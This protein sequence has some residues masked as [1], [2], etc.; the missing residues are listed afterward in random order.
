MATASKEA[1]RRDAEGD[2][3]EAG[4]G[5]CACTG[6]VSGYN[7]DEAQLAGGPPGCS[8]GALE[9]VAA[10]VGGMRGEEDGEEG[11]EEGCEEEEVVIAVVAA[12]FAAGVLC[13][14]RGERVYV[15]LLLWVPEQC[16]ALTAED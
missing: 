8:G 3:E 5:G 15:W 2:G 11:E 4:C 7:G 14:Y 13:H 6:G 16:T 10:C 1:S 9:G 12:A